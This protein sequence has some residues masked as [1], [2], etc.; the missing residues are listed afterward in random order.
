MAIVVNASDY[1]RVMEKLKAS[2]LTYSQSFDL[3][4]KAFEHTA[5]YD[6]MIANYMGTVNQAAETLS[7]SGRSEFPRTFN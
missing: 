5:A 7:T 6:G 4:L 1:D 2:G 3:M